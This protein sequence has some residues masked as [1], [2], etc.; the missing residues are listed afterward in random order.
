ME[1]LSE[2]S[3]RQ[4]IELSRDPVH[5]LVLTLDGKRQFS[6]DLEHRFHEALGVVPLLYLSPRRVF[7]G[8]GG[9]GLI[10][11]RLLK[12]PFVERVVVCDFDPEITRLAREH[13]ALVRLNEGSLLDPRV[14]LIH[15][16]AFARLTRAGDELDLVIADFPL[17]ATRELGRLYSV[18]L[19]RAIH[20]RLGPEGALAVHGPTL[21]APAA[22]L[23]K[24]L[25]SVFE[26]VYWYGVDY[27]GRGHHGFAIASKRPLTRV[28]STPA[29]S[30]WLSDEV[31]DALFARPKD[32]PTEQAT[33]HSVEEPEL[34]RALLAYA[35]LSTASAYPYDER[36]LTL[37]MGGSELS[38]AEW[39]LALPHLERQSA[40]I[41][42]VDEA[43]CPG[44]RALLEARGYVARNRFARLEIPV[45]ER[46]REQVVDLWE[47]HDDGSVAELCV[48]DGP[49]ESDPDVA[50]M[51]AAYLTRH[52]MIFNDG[53]AHPDMMK[54]PA[55]H[56][57]CRDPAGKAVALLRVR[58]GPT[59]EIDAVYGEGTRRQ[60]ALS[61]ILCTRYLQ[62]QF[63][64]VVAGWSTE[65]LAPTYQ[66][67]G[68]ALLGWFDVLSRA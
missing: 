32:E 64:G 50:R 13:P 27:R 31:A 8:G 35:A 5:G 67:L 34:V 48:I 16:D 68:A 65:R 2:R 9:D 30:R 52:G 7:V 58:P 33:V 26:H 63:G 59:T 20:A 22:I 60:N 47:R 66:R 18:E 51:F 57:L 29:W 10:A 24:T 42:Y 28:R 53:P 41:F 62:E 43:R 46:S 15:D 56:L 12:F 11:A 36:F 39:A 25:A 21:P 17:P 1:L 6:E 45:G 54:L 4:H 55:L 37:R 38:L 44:G 61:I 14:E 49:A 40:L 23:R 3:D 19:Y